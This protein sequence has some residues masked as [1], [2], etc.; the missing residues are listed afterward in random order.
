M[1]K[2]GQSAAKNTRLAQGAAVVLLAAVGVLGSVGI[3]GMEKPAKPGELVIKAAEV[4]IP[5]NPNAAARTV[6]YASLSGRL[7]LLENAPKP[8]ESAETTAADE[9]ASAPPP[10]PPAPVMKYLGP[11]RV[12]ALML[13]LMSDN[14][15]QRFVKTGDHLSDDSLVKRVLERAVEIEKGGV[16]SLI[17][18]SERTGG[19]TTAGAN[20]PAAGGAK[21][22]KP[23]PSV[24]GA[25]GR[26]RDPSGGRV[27]SA[28]EV[29]SFLHEGT[30]KGGHYFD[31]AGNAVTDP[32]LIRLFQVRSKVAET[33][34]FKDPRQIDNYARSLIEKEDARQA[35]DPKGRK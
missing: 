31:A 26:V 3:P 17:E 35:D 28:A 13:G 14:G 23:W 24:S 21:P 32:K 19:L 15:H 4:R 7:G 22:G 25:A 34:Q 30:E 10:A 12:G 8:P 5:P 29:E 9:S 16:V 20:P 11:A 27:M 1:G 33:E 2:T 18:L 6:D